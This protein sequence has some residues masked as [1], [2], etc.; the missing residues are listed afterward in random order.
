MKK[1]IGMVLFVWGILI[2]PGIS[3]ANGLVGEDEHHCGMAD[4]MG[5]SMMSFS[6]W[7]FQILLIIIG[8]L[9]IYWL[10]KQIQ[11]K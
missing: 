11:K 7:T 2:L 4:F 3:Y 6:Y 10:I 5:G 9:V 1:I 8:L